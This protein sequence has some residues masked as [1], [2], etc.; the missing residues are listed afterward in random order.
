[1]IEISYKDEKDY[2]DQG[3]K[4]YDRYIRRQGDPDTQYHDHWHHKIPQM[5]NFAY[6]PKPDSQWLPTE[7]ERI[8]TYIARIGREIQIWEEYSQIGRA[9]V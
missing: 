8:D 7:G 2:D 6:Q 4:I 9:H 5:Q 3:H 1:M